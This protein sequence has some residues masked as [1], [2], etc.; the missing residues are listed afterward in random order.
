M[1]EHPIEAKL[2]NRLVQATGLLGFIDRHPRLCAY[3]LAYLLTM[4]L[5]TILVLVAGHRT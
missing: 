3:L 2:A 4:M 1:A 5:L